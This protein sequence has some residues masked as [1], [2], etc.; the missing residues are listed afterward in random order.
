MTDDLS[1]LAGRTQDIYARQASRFDADRSRRLHERAWLDRFTHGLRRGA[2]ILDLGCGGGEPIAAHLIDSGYAV[3]GVD[4]CEALIALARRRRPG[5]DWRVA[6][7]RAL[8]LA[9]RFDGVLGWNSVFHLTRDEQ[10][11]LLP[12]LCALVN[13]GGRLMI[14]VGPK[15]G[16]VAGHVGEERV[17]HASLAPA[18]Y[19]AILNHAGLHVIDFVAEDPE[20]ASQSVLLA[21]RRD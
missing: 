8:D 12:R 9:G 5:A 16:E 4:A 19:A 11:A 10:R 6:D 13:P 7:M 1:S 17:Y 15:D 3:T 14:T 20:C 21:A 18:E 2:S